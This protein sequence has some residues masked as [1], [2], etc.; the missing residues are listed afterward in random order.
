MKALKFLLILGFVFAASA[1]AKAAV[2]SIEQGRS[3]ASVS[4]KKKKHTPK[5]K[6][7]PSKKASKKAA[8][9][10]APVDRTR[11]TLKTDISFDDNILH[12]K[13][14]MPDESL[15]KVE[16]EKGLSDLLGARKHFKDRLSEASEQE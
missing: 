8:L 13:Y 11:G 12:G 3:I 10:P 1:Q 4:K 9:K 16:N 5:K 7:K 14:Q 2:S 6:K 15:V